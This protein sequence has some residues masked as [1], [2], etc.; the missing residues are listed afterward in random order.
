MRN[1]SLRKEL[2]ENEEPIR[3][4]KEEVKR[5][6]KSKS[7]DPPGKIVR[8]I[9]EVYSDGWTRGECLSSNC[10]QVKFTRGG[11]FKEGM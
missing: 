9:K 2:P 8:H 7:H 3:I 6:C 1:L 4:S 11:T 5:S 10:G